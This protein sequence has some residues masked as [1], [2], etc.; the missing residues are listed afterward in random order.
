[1]INKTIGLMTY[2]IAQN[3]LEKYPPDILIN[4]SKETCTTFD[5]YRAEEL[6]EIGKMETI[7][8]LKNIESHQG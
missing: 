6:I 2:Q 4:I 1:V 7:S 3:H 5:F 8:T